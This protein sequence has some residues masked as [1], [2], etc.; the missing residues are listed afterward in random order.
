[1]P[2]RHG[3]VCATVLHVTVTDNDIICGVSDPA[4]RRINTTSSGLHD[5]YYVTTMGDRDCVHTVTHRYTVTH[6]S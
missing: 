6:M 2:L 3:L 5:H 4:R 1:M